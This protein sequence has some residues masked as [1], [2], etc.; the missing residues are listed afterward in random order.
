[1]GARTYKDYIARTTNTAKD[2]DTFLQ[3]VW[4]FLSL[5]RIHGVT[6]RNRVGDELARKE[7]CDLAI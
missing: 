6:R 4:N 7:F 3:I 5:G 1:M 2:L